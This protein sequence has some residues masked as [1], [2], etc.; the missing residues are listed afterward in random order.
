MRMRLHARASTRPPRRSHFCSAGSRAPDRNPPSRPRLRAWLAKNI[1]SG[2][3]P[4][5]CLRGGFSPAFAAQIR[6]ASKKMM[7]TPAGSRGPRGA[8]KG[9]RGSVT[10]V[11]ARPFG[12]SASGPRAAYVEPPDSRIGALMEA[13]LY[14]PDVLPIVEGMPEMT[15]GPDVCGPERRTD[16]N[17]VKPMTLVYIGSAGTKT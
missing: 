9:P 12:A 17:K 6:P 16:Y 15:E 14:A 2:T 8:S 7:Q 3:T 1:L 11:A 13:R 5:L 4:A 10:L